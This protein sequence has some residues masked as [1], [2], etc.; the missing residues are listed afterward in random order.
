MAE[1][2]ALG[3]DFFQAVV[4]AAARDIAASILPGGALLPVLIEHGARA[5]WLCLKGKKPQQQQRVM[6]AVTQIS[7]ARSRSFVERELNAY[8]FPADHLQEMISYFAA[9]P[10]SMRRAISR[11]NDNGRP[12][13]LLSQLPGSVEEAKRFVPLRPPHYQPGVQVPAYDYRLDLLL[14]QGGFAEVWKAHHILQDDSPPVA[15]KFCLD[16]DLLVSLKTEIKVLNKLRAYE[17]QQ[18]LVQLLS[19]A[20]SA[21]PPFLVYEYVDGGD[22]TAWLASCDGKRPS[23]SDVLRVLKMATRPLAYA[24][25]RGV[26]H[27]DLKPANLLVTRDGRVKI[28]DF[29]IGAIV[30]DVEAHRD[31]APDITAATRLRGAFTPCYADPQQCRGDPPDPRFDVYALGVIAYQLLIGDVSC[32]MGPAWRSELE[33]CGTPA[34]LLNVIAACTDVSAKRLPDAAALLSAL[35]QVNLEKPKPGEPPEHGVAVKFCMHCGASVE[36]IDCFCMQC[37]QAIQRSRG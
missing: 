21:T 26:V 2:T 34:A 18:A 5:L 36:R 3:E 22:L 12:T 33:E 14:G 25:R 13:T 20:Y 6:D 31:Y 29:G 4:R 23:V 19:T 15:L 1:D 9:I 11:P 16:S 30:A 27:R 32:F 35:E 7:G 10:M 8:R 17:D 24:H 28:C 37:G